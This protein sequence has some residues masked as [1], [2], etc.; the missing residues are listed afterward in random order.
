MS[1]LGKIFD[2]I[3]RRLVALLQSNA[4][5]S[6]VEL[7]R[8]LGVARSTVHD[9]IRRLEKAGAIL[10]YQVVLARDVTG[11]SAQSIVLLSI[12][13]QQQRSVIEALGRLPEIKLCHTVSGEY[14]LFLLIETPQ[15]EDLDA[16]IDEVTSIAGVTRSQSFILLAKKFDRMTDRGPLAQPGGSAAVRAAD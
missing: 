3:D 11:A 6:T 12:S 2:E 5:Q 16:V 9:R 4:R 13:Q 1:W 7:A 14:D 15:L 10:G 8:R